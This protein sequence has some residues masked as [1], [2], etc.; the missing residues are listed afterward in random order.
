MAGLLEDLSVLGF[1]GN[2]L[3]LLASDFLMVQ[4]RFFCDFMM[5]FPLFSGN[6]GVLE[7]EFLFLTVAAL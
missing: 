6:G 4:T 7:S 3:E 5:L 1:P 2:A